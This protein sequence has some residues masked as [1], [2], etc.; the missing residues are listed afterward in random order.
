MFID[1]IRIKSLTYSVFPPPPSEN[2]Q[3]K[4]KLLISSGEMSLQMINYSA[5]QKLVHFRTLFPDP[6]VWALGKSPRVSS[7]HLPPKSELF[8][9]PWSPS[10]NRDKDRKGSSPSAAELQLCSVLQEPHEESD[11]GII[12]GGPP[13][14]GQSWENSAVRCWEWVRVGERKLNSTLGEDACTTSAPILA[15][16]PPQPSLLS[17]PSTL[18]THLLW[19]GNALICGRENA[20]QTWGRK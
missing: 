11:R 8:I 10:K 19:H 14:W 6:L 17:H 2:P 9:S 20:Q 15:L 12:S 7:I 16:H 3:K 5:K 1:N 18:Q 4:S 13:S